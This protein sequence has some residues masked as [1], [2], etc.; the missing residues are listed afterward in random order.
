MKI[1]SCSI[2][3]LTITIAIL[4]I[5][6][7]VYGQD[8]IEKIDNLLNSYYSDKKINGNFLIAEKG[9]VI[10]SRSFGY[11]NEVTKEKLNENSIFELAS[12]SKQFT[13]MAIMILKEKGKLNLDDDINKYLPELS[14]YKGITIRNLLNHTGGLPDYMELMDSLFDKS[15]IATNKDIIAL[16]SKHQPKI[17]F[18]PNTKYEYS[19]TGYALLASIIEKASGS[20]FAD[21]L[22]KNIFKPLKM[23]NTFVYTRRLMP[24]KIEN[25]AFG[26]VYSDSLKTYSLPDELTETKQVIWLDGIAGDGCVNSTVNDLLKWDRALYTNKLLS[27][28]GMKEIFE[29]AT[30]NDKSKTKYGLGWF[31]DDNADFGKIVYHTGGWYGYVSVIDRHITNDKTIIILQNHGD[32]SFS[33]KSI[34]YLLY[35][36]PLP[37]KKVWKETVLTTEQLQKLVG[38]YEVDKDFEIK[39]TLDKQQLFTQLTGQDAFPIY[40]ESELLFFQKVVDAQFQFE[41]NEKGEI[42][43]LFL[44]QHGNKVEA[45]RTK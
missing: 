41:Q 24:K 13:A 15:K 25:Y 18:E 34:R 11:S 16:F 20:T 7:L 10:Y 35:D 28:A 12:C 40:P 43:K 19:N 32:V 3:K 22:S 23:K 39:I 1:I 45:K 27:K 14:N 26:Y 8:R 38:T 29:V 2:V 31:T 42:V 9:K 44:L 36:K 33:L 6:Q 5:G 37:I 21:F 30:L 4:L 17:L